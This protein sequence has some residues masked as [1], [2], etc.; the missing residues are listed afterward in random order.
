MRPDQL[1]QRLAVAVAGA[2][3]GANGRGDCRKFFVNLTYNCRL[4]ASQA[5][6]RE[7]ESLRPLSC[8]IWTYDEPKGCWLAVVQSLARRNP[9]PARQAAEPVGLDSETSFEQG[10][11]SLD[12]SYLRDKTPGLFDH[13]IGCQFLERNEVNSGVVAICGFRIGPSWLDTPH[14]FLNGNH[15]GHERAEETTTRGRVFVNASRAKHRRRR[16]RAK[17]PPAL[18]SERHECVSRTSQPR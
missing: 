4:A 17:G 16:E 11:S 7:F 15:K 14:F 9:H 5:G 8:L 12:H 2:N 1:S 6:C 10:F 3:R 13:E 18:H